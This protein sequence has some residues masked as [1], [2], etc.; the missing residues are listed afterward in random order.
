[1]DNEAEAPPGVNLPTPSHVTCKNKAFIHRCCATFNY[2]LISM[3]FSA[4]TIAY[5]DA[6]EG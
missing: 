3:Y 5:R 1:M 2:L 4:T 6:V